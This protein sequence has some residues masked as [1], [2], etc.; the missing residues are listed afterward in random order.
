MKR[1]ITVIIS[2]LL[3][4]QVWAHSYTSTSVLA[5]GNFVKVS[6]PASGVYRLS[7]SELKDMGLDPSKV[8]IFGYG[9]ALLA[10]DFR[11]AKIDDLPEVPIYKHTSANGD[12]GKSD[13]ILFYAQGPVSW[14]FDGELFVH[15][16][17][18]YSTLGY[19]FLTD[20]AGEQKLLESKQ[21]TSFSS[22]AFSVNTFTAYDVYEKD[23][24]NIIDAIGSGEGGGKEF[25]SL[26]KAS[27]PYVDIDFRFP[28]LITSQRMSFRL[29]VASSAASRTSFTCTVG[30]STNTTYV[31]ARSSDKYEKA[32]TARGTF[33]MQPADS[34]TQR[35]RIRYNASGG[36]DAGYLNFLEVNAQCSMTMS[37][38]SLM[39][40]NIEH[41]GSSTPSIYNLS[42]AN[43]NVQI[44][45]VSDLTNIQSLPTQLNNGVMSFEVPNNTAAKIV[46]VDVSSSNFPSPAVVGKI[47]NQNLHSLSDIE[48]VIICPSMFVSQAEKLAQAHADIDG[49]S[50]AV[51]TDQQVFNEF[52]SGTPDAT[53]YRWVMK[54]LYDRSKT[55]GKAPRYLLLLGDGSY[56]NRGINPNSAPHTLLT[57][58]ADNS[59]SEV[60]AY[61]TDD[62]FAFLDD[63]EGISDLTARMDIGVGRLP[64]NT[65]AEAQD[66]VDKT[67]EYMQNRTFG[68]W[69]TQLVFLADDGD[70]GLHTEV[71]DYAA[72][73]VRTSAPDYITNKIYI[74]SYQ[75]EVSASGES[76]PIAK[77]K[78][79]NLLQNG[80][81]FFDYSG[82]GGY[83]NIASEAMLTASEIRNLNNANLGFWML[84]T[85][86]FANYDAKKTSAS[87]YAVLK[88]HGGALAVLSACRTVYAS[89]NKVFNRHLC[90]SLLLSKGNVRLG[91]A[92]RLAKNKTGSEENKLAFILLGDPA[93][94]LS[95]PNDYSVTTTST[96]ETLTALST[97]TLTGYISD[98]N[99]QKVSDFNG[100]MQ[101]TI[102]DKM[103]TLKTLDND[104]T[105][106]ADKIIKEFNDYPNTIFS[107]EVDVKDGEFSA[108]FMVPLDIKYNFGNG[109][110]AYYAYDP[111][112]K[113]EAIGHYHDLIVGGSSDLDFSDH[114][115]PELNIYLN[116]TYF[117]DG[118]KTSDSPHFYADITDRSGINTSGSGIGHDLLLVLDNDLK[119]TYVLN[120]HFVSK[121][122]DYTSGQVSYPLSG[123]EEGKH[124]LMFRVWD[125]FNNSTTK[126][127]RFE[128]VKD[129]GVTVHR[130]LTYPN[131]ATSD[132]TL[133]FVVEH[134]QPDTRMTA[135]VN[136]YNLAGQLV[137]SHTQEAVGLTNIDL[138]LGEY[139]IKEGAY[140]YRIELQ[141]PTQT[142]VYKSG[143]LI[144]L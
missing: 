72:E 115:G 94:R 126:T 101:I 42:N 93:V 33:N 98:D 86:G 114:E 24:V 124:E 60:K 125:L 85:C 64:A 91:D 14:S 108:D 92:V 81:L 143:K 29:D 136:I 137:V 70:S 105:N 129:L 102:Y 79:D 5:E 71:A 43:A 112:N 7:Y 23:S 122:N 57:Y 103:Q 51:V 3:L 74:D 142:S 36:N 133:H 95:Y 22:G 25:Y 10:K 128:V 83:N 144:I 138:N 106:E 111:T 27:E 8:R 58:Q 132:Q 40:S 69:K 90:D 59:T 89:N 54:M 141:S 18:H 37:G 52:S 119:Q 116:S 26:L 140:I 130:V 34:E 78:F 13:Y 53:A 56:D 87:E 55:S 110:I 62:Y 17:N 11:Q 97:H 113:K 127:L 30:S 120:G 109:R 44:W 2:S 41:Y 45:N 48:Y 4:M 134:D 68:K 6:V 135:V 107:G 66:M 75:Q 50:W 88:R 16:N 139:N 73:N 100:K 65:T 21:A 47:A 61:S 32:V 131:P 76:Y 118:D 15:T 104:H 39:L 31:A 19:Y 38:N 96:L 28:N 80:V 67:I 63:R 1:V 84:A 99:G 82:H 20:K 77:T 12:F 49:F 117:T 46:A 35:V 121:P 123:L 9:G